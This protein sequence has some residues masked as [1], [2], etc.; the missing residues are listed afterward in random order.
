FSPGHTTHSGVGLSASQRFQVEAQNISAQLKDKRATGLY[1]Y[2]DDIHRPQVFVEMAY[3]QAERWVFLL[4]KLRKGTLET[5]STTL[6]YPQ[7]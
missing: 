4:N 7:Q 1:L 3:D 2:L 6:L 5:Q